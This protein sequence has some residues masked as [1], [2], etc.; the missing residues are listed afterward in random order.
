MSL[1]QCQLCLEITYGRVVLTGRFPYKALEPL[2]LAAEARETALYFPRPWESVSPEGTAKSIKRSSYSLTSIPL[3]H[4]FVS[5]LL[6]V[7]QL[8]RMTAKEALAHP[9]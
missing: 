1:Y 6:T 9:V 7:D 8:Q 2:A 3:A 4:D 5:R